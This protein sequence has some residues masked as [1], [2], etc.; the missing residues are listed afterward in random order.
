MATYKVLQAY[1]KE[2]NGFAAKTCWI[3]HVKH[4]HG[5]VSRS[6]PNRQ[7]PADRVHPCPPERREPIEEALRHHGMIP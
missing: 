1:L 2:R 7:H 3:A 6:A 4:E 5:L